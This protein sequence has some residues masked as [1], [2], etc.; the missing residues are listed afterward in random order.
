MIGGLALHKAL[1]GPDVMPFDAYAMAHAVYFAMFHA[2][3][4]SWLLLQLMGFGLASASAVVVV[5]VMMVGSWFGLIQ[6]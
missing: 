2:P 1:R 3:P 4:D 5:L 6:V